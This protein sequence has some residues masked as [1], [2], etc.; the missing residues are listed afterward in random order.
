MQYDSYFSTSLEDTVWVETVSS[1]LVEKIPVD[2]ASQTDHFKNSLLFFR[3]FVRQKQ[4][5]EKRAIFFSE[6]FINKQKHFHKK[7]FMNRRKGRGSWRKLDEKTT[8][9][10]KEQYILHVIAL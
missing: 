5:S 2:W 7:I 9:W 6:T 4:N 8:L 3:V 10:K 1:K